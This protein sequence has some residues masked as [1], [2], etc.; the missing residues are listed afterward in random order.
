MNEVEKILKDNNVGTI[1]KAQIPSANTTNY[2][3]LDFDHSIKAYSNLS[4]KMNELNVFDKNNF[5][6]PDEYKVRLAKKGKNGVETNAPTVKFKNDVP[7]VGKPTLPPNALGWVDVGTV[8]GN[9]NLNLHHTCDFTINLKLEVC[10]TTIFAFTENIKAT[11]AAKLEDFL[12]AKIPFLGHILDFIRMLKEWFDYIMYYVNKILQFIKCM[13]DLIAAITN[14]INQLIN[15]PNT[16]LRQVSQCLR[17]LKN[18]L[19]NSINGMLTGGAAGSILNDINS[20]KSQ[21]Q[22]VGTQFSSSV[23]GI[24][25]N[26]QQ[27]SNINGDNILDS[28]SNS[29]KNVGDVAKG[30]IDPNINISTLNQLTNITNTQSI[31]NSFKL[32]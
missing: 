4:D 24:K 7:V 10:E 17:D 25:N 31:Q 12:K 28:Y 32:P 14:F 22:S 2:I 19:L 30:V 18:L 23:S 15:L 9:S 21:V 1:H 8:I 3:T 5:P 20:M 16:I 13:Q 6:S 27:L 11:F 29:A 26:M